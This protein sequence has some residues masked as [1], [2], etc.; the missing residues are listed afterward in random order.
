MAASKSIN[1]QKRQKLSLTFILLILLQ[2]FERVHSDDFMVDDMKLNQDQLPTQTTDSSV[3]KSAIE[4]RE[5]RWIGKVMPYKIDASLKDWTELIESTI[6]HINR[7]F[8][9]CFKIR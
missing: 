3:L 5:Y 1:T 8:C 7:M 2:V 4:G 9:G 6:S